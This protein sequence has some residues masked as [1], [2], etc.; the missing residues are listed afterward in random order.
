MDHER[1]RAGPAQPSRAWASCR[2]PLAITAG[3]TV[4]AA[5]CGA[6]ATVRYFTN[7]DVAMTGLA[8]G[9]YGGEPGAHLVYVGFLPGLLVK[10]AYRVLPH[11]PWY[12]LLHYGSAVAA[13]SMVTW[14]AWTCRARLTAPLLV[15]LAA[16]LTVWGSLLFVKPSFTFTGFALAIAATCLLLAAPMLGD[17]TRRRTAVAGGVLLGAAGAIRW[18]SMLGAVAIGLPL[19][20]VG[21]WKAGR[22]DAIRFVVAAAASV[23]VVASANGLAERPT[24][25]SGY[26][27]VNAAREEL[28]ATGRLNAV[29]A[30]PDDPAVVAM[31]RD[32][33]WTIN[34]VWIFASWMIEDPLVYSATKLERLVEVSEQPQF[35]TPWGKAWHDVVADRGWMVLGILL[36]AALAVWRSRRSAPFVAAQTMWSAA[37]ATYVSRTQRFPERIVVPLSIL[38]MTALLVHGAALA[39]PATADTSTD[40]D[41]NLGAEPPRRPARRAVRP[42][43][44]WALVAAFAVATVLPLLGRYSAVAL[45]RSNDDDR[46][47]LDGELATLRTV[48]PDGQF[49]VIASAMGFG[50]A[51]VF[52]VDPLFDDRRLLWSTWLSQSPPQ[53]RRLGEMGLTQDLLG[54]IVDQ[55]HRYFVLGRPYLP[56]FQQAYRERVGIEPNFVRLA[57]MGGRGSVYAVRSKDRGTG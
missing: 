39:R 34:D 43:V 27:E 52:S 36:C 11:V 31:L 56:Y 15:P 21:L 46:E 3:W 26:A 12:A 48:D 2:A 40:D 19:L 8:S 35:A 24:D 16:I 23:A 28:H 14:L 45:S 57:D 38:L 44:A 1:E 9:S 13:L 47:R 50:G 6:L 25:W 30:S 53:I 4:V 22:A 10:S 55:S 54:S 7:D 5:L 20:A 49:V 37:I 17:V 32:N 29:L 51:N 41:T 42:V 18:D 33:D